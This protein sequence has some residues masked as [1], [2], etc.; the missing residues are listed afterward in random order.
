MGVDLTL[1]DLHSAILNAFDFADDHM[2]AFF[3][4]NKPWDEESGI[5]SPYCEEEDCHSTDYK[6][7]GFNFENGAQFLYIFR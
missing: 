6:L 7:S 4:N 2:H 3:M 1:H 5:Y